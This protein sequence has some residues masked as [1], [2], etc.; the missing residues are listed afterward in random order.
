MVEKEHAYVKTSSTS[1]RGLF[2][3]NDIPAGDQIFSI[4]RPLIAVLDSDR[5]SNSCSNCFQWTFFP[6]ASYEKW[7]DAYRPEIKACS[8]CKVLKFCDRVCWRFLPCGILYF[9]NHWT[10]TLLFR[11]VKLKHGRNS[12]NLNANPSAE[13]L[14]T[15]SCQ[16]PFALQSR[17]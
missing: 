6:V 10:D 4:E 8:Q 13:S 12:I 3:K 7:G 1:G 17:S 2:A 15:M 14:R 5:C 11:H 16:L 9:L